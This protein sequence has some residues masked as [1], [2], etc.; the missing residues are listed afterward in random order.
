M[1]CD[2]EGAMAVKTEAGRIMPVSRRGSIHPFDRRRSGR[3]PT[4]G[5][6]GGRRGVYFSSLL[7]RPSSPFFRKAVTALMAASSFNFSGGVLPVSP[8]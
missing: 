5:R 7:F 3:L 2:I 6:P 4:D 1:R 8:R